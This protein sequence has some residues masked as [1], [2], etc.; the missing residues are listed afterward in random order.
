MIVFLVL[1]QLAN[2][3]YDDH[4]GNEATTKPLAT[5]KFCSVLFRVKGLQYLD[6]YNVTL[7]PSTTRQPVVGQGVGANSSLPGQ[8]RLVFPAHG[9]R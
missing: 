8:H 4:F 1:E 6:E 3:S 7:E 9:I 5:G 2:H